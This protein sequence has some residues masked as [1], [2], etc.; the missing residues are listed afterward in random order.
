[1]PIAKIVSGGQTGAD[2][3]G[4]EAAIYCSLPYGGWIPKGRKQEQGRRIPDKYEGL[5]ETGSEDYAVR[6]GHV[7]EAGM[8]VLE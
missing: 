8:S 7:P 2:I 6:R 3:G 5:T 4:L 1:M